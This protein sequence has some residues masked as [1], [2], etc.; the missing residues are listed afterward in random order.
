MS[1]E[2]EPEAGLCARC[3]HARIQ[4]SARGSRFWRCLR[5]D[6]DPSYRRYPPLPVND[7]RGFEAHEAPGRAGG[8]APEVG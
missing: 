4:G 6:A 8:D 3:R 7:C 5:A 1:T 2:R